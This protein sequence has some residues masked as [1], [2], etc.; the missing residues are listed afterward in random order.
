[1]TLNKADASEFEIKERQAGEVTILELK[2]RVALGRGSQALNDR[3]QALIDQGRI[4][5][6][7]RSDKKALKSW[8]DASFVLPMKRRDGR[9]QECESCHVDWNMT[10][11]TTWGGGG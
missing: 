2:G 10:F 11:L 4:K 5:L 3:L 9:E 6:L 1:M 7:D 8:M